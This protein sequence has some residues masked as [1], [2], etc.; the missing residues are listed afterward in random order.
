M[1]LRAD[2]AARRQQLGAERFAEFRATLL[3]LLSAPG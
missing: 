1:R 2:F 3:A